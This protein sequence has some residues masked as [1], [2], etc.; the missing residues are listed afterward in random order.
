MKNCL[1]YFAIGATLHLSSSNAAKA[2][3][4]ACWMRKVETEWPRMSVES[5]GEWVSKI[6]IGEEILVSAK[7]TLNSLSP[8]EVHVEVLTGLVD[9]Q[10]ELKNPVVLHMLPSGVDAAGAYL[11]QTVI[12]PSARSGLHGYAIRLLPKHPDSISLFLPGLIRW[13]QAPSPVAELQAR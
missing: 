10:G 7:V 11:F 8:E 3:E 12:Q 4:V 1:E 9:A 6:G 2:R 13:A 5:V